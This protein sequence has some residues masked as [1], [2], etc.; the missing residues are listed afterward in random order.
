VIWFVANG[1]LP[2][3]MTV[4]HRDGNKENNALANLEVVTGGDNTRHAGALGLLGCKRKLDE[5]AV[6]NIY[7]ESKGDASVSEVARRFNISRRT[8][9]DIRDGK[10]WAGVTR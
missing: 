7:N 3:G 5:E 8:V 6:V 2:P 9:R 1:A 10:T 4:N